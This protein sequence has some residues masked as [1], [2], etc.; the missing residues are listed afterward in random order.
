MTR[1]LLDEN[2]PAGAARGLE[3]AGHEVAL[4]A[5]VAPGLDDR[6]VLALARGEARVLITFDADFGDLVFQRGELPPPAIVYLRLHPIVVEEVLAIALRA[7]QVSPL[8]SFV[9]ATREGIEDGNAVMMWRSTSEAG[10]EF[11]TLGANRRMPADF[12]GV[13]LVSF[14]PEVVGKAPEKFVFVGARKVGGKSRR[15]NVVENQRDGGSVFPTHVG[16]NRRTPAH[17]RRRTSV[18]HARGDEPYR[19]R[20]GRLCRPHLVLRASRGRCSRM[21]AAK[22]RMAFPADHHRPCRQ[23][24]ARLG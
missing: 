17:G 11:C 6:G 15:L 7:L 23:Q 18:P 2:F 3:A 8:A 9:V 13:Q 22:G 12:D 24:G 21:A 16:M 1:L 10:F 4:V 19:T 5:R 20:C 14:H